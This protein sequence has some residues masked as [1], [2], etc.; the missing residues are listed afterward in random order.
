MKGEGLGS[1][2]VHVAFHVFK[3]TLSQVD[4]P[5]MARCTGEA[6]DHGIDNAAACF[7]G[8]PDDVQKCLHVCCG[9]PFYMVHRC[10]TLDK[11]Q[12]FTF[13]FWLWHL[14]DNDIS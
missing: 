7:E 13:C 1:T 4:E 11:G 9:Y 8:V 14:C 5:T 2:Y 12:C 6:L 3:L 10:I